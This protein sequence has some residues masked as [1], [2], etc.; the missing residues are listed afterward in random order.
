M[1]YEGKFLIGITIISV[2]LIILIYTMFMQ[3]NESFQE[4]VITSEYIDK[5]AKNIIEKS[6][7]IDLPPPTV[8]PS[9][10]Q[11]M[12]GVLDSLG[13]SSARGAYA[14]RSLFNTYTGYHVQIR[15]ESDG[16]YANVSFDNNGT[17]ISIIVD[18]QRPITKTLTEWLNG[19]VAYVSVWY[20]QSG[21]G[22][23]LIQPNE[24]HQPY[25][26][27]NMM[28]M[29]I[30][31][32]GNQYMEVDGTN[33][34][35]TPLTISTMITPTS[36]NRDWQSVISKIKN[37]RERHFG[38]WMRR[39]CRMLLYQR[40]LPRRNIHW[41]SKS[42]VN[43]PLNIVCVSSPSSNTL[44]VNGRQRA[45]TSGAIFAP[46]DAKLNIGG[47]TAI[48]TKFKGRI[49]HVC[50]FVKEHD[51]QEIHDKFI[52]A[53]P[54]QTPT[55]APVN[56]LVS[57]QLIRRRF[58]L[59]SGVASRNTENFN[60]AFCNSLTTELTYV[61][62]FNIPNANYVALEYTGWITVPQSGNYRFGLTSDDGS[63]LAL[64]LD[65][66]WKIITSAYG[67]KPP[68]RSPPSSGTQYLQANTLYP[69]RIR[70]HEQGGGQ[71]LNVFWIPP[72]NT[73][74]TRIPF[75]VFRSA[76]DKNIR[77]NNYPN[78][79]VCEK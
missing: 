34:N 45:R 18:G 17:P 3:N 29:E 73:S 68:E 37:G 31:F 33:F 61:Q 11:E 8:A 60:K 4:I 47:S 6:E 49:A 63:D 36:T 66:Q 46:N 77:G 15:R 22:N 5:M 79:A 44:Y 65:N 52:V 28:P 38:V 42:F 32:S 27:T 30:Q 35:S 25:I 41:T 16:V 23:H 9:T 69:I 14:L 53:P 57:G 1:N 56:Q 24:L 20:D 59:N 55:S 76:P 26:Q 71:A 62:N 43:V 12:S 50:I 7:I 48:H 39:D 51:A 72:N 67:Y 54:A 2:S 78:P 40:Y 21:K 75:S 19:S 13:S 10:V 70:F 74:F 64:Y 58:V